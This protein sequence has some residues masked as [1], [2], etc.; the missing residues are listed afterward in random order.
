MSSLPLHGI[1]V[2]AVEQ[3][4]AAPLAT[5]HLADL[6][7]RVIKVERCGDGDFA[8]HYDTAVHGI[9]SHFVWL[10]RGKQSVAVDLKHPD[11]VA[12]V[13]R[14]IATAD[15]VVQNLGP[16]AAERLGLGAAQLRE[17][18]PDLIVA[19]LSGYGADGP[20]RERKAYDMLVQAETGLCSLTGTADGPAKAGV[21]V[22]DIATAMYTLSA[23]QA[24]LFRRERTG[25]GATV[26][27]TMFDAT[28]EWLTHPM[29]LQRYAGEQ[30]PR[31]GVAHATIAPYDAY[32]TA[33][34]QILIG[35]Q[36]D[37]GWRALVTEVFAAPALADDPRFATNIARVRHRAEVDAIV[38]EHTRARA[39]ADL[40]ERLAAAGVP[41]ARLNSMADLVAHPELAGRR[42]QV[43]T[44]AGPVEALAPP[45]GFDDAALAMGAVPALGQHTDAL[46]TE[47]GLTTGHIA[48][49][50]SRHVV[51]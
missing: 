36:N 50:R 45:M 18:Q 9:S 28:T 19:N 17:R 13:H 34:G 22:A 51:Q 15:V 39:T 8:R 25:Q 29:Y 49:L 44:E 3:A 31:M 23:I 48:D 41:A 11:G 33:D 24:A 21:P 26:A 37:R 12:L 7:A 30:L 38:A 35:V 42:R 43:D 14:M 10:N 6:G 46:L 16:G 47:L 4:V 5:R 40:E 32:P 20:Y 27:V 1:T 2:I